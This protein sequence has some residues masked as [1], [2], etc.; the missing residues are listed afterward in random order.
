[1]SKVVPP[2]WTGEWRVEV[3]DDEGNVLET[4]TFTVG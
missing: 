1:S 4:L 2:A 3:R